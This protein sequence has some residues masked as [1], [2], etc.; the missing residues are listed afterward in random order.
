MGLQRAEKWSGPLE[1]QEKKAAFVIYE[2]L[3]KLLSGPK[4]VKNMMM[5]LDDSNYGSYRNN[6]IHRYWR[7]QEIN[8]LD[9]YLDCENNDYQRPPVFCMNEAHRNIIINP[10][11]T[12]SENKKLFLLINNREHHKWYRSMNSSQALALGVFGN[13]HQSN[14]LGILSDLMCDEGLPMFE[15][16]NILPENFEMEKKINYL[17]E[18]RSTSVDVFLSGDYQI[19]I[20]CKFT[21]EEVGPCSHLRIDK[22]KTNYCDGK[23]YSREN[24]KEV[25]CIYKNSSNYW[26][27]IPMFFD[28]EKNK[29]IDYC[30]LAHNYQLVR[31]ILAAGLKEGTSV[32]AM[33]GHAIL[34]YDERNP[35]CH[36]GGK[37]FSAYSET[38]DALLDPEMLRKISWQ[39]I[40]D[41]IRGKKI[42][43]WL[44]EALYQKYGL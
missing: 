39:R 16:V 19:A 30:P 8:S 24:Q 13:L 28:W 29:A 44:T 3:R 32:S 34:V 36:K 6:L 21:E 20:E 11:S 2:K 25:C 14:Q 26:D 10:D 9:N 22:E 35:A 1:G 41:Q 33:L 42:L 4:G 31:N 43:F 37:I 17:G 5:S 38:R 15:T 23:F 7:Y 18:R 40:V 12:E 27:Y